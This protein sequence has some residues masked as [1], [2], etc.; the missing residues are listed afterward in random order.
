MHEAE[1]MEV[2]F[3]DEVNSGIFCCR[4]GSRIITA[5]EERQFRNRAA[6]TFNCQDL[7]TTVRRAFEDS[8][9]SAL[10]DEQSSARIAFRKEKLA[11]LVM[12][13]YSPFGK[14]S[15]FGFREPVKDL[16]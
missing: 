9:T 7:L 2:L 6:G 1:G 5:I 14:E 4:C 13:R 11:F 3:A 16:H 15:E 10:N 8:H 12:A